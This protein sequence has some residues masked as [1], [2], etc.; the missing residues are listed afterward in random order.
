MDYVDFRV[1]EPKPPFLLLLIMLGLR[2]GGLYPDVAEEG[3]K[4][5]VS[6]GVNL[7]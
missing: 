7:V 3:T 6:T 1:A 2:D 5:D 4:R